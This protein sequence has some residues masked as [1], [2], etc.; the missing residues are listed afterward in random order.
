ML[1]GHL[2]V[3]LYVHYRCIDAE[4]EG[5]VKIFE[6]DTISLPLHLKE[7]YPPSSHSSV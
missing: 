5:F 6:S 7:S 3:I 1:E 2:A 4:K